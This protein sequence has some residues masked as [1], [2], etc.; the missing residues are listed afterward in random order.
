MEFTMEPTKRRLAQRET[1]KKERE[2]QILRHHVI[3]IDDGEEDED[4]DPMTTDYHFIATKE[5]A[6]EISDAVPF[7]GEHSFPAEP[8]Y[9]TQKRKDARLPYIKLFI[10]RG[11]YMAFW[12]AKGAKLSVAALNPKKEASDNKKAKAK[13]AKEA[14]AKKVG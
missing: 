10:D 3:I 12:N 9:L 4:G 7:K 5:D 8:V 11:D 1:I 2:A 14:K 6:K 13:E